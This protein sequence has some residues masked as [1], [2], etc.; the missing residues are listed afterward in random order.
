MSAALL[1]VLSNISFRIRKAK[2]T[3]GGQKERPGEPVGGVVEE[4]VPPTQRTEEPA[5]G[6]VASRS[7]RFVLCHLLTSNREG[8]EP[9]VSGVC[10]LLSGN[11]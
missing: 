10:P 2:L 8:H 1:R 6:T 9:T 5:S 4:A 3:G 7:V 11:N